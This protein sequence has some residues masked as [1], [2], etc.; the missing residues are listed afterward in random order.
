MEIIKRLW[1]DEAGFIISVE[2][3]LIATI[4]VIGLLV[5]LVTIR[6]SITGELSDVGGAI[7]DLNQSYVIYGIIGPSAA[8]SGSGFADNADTN[9]SPGDPPG[10]M[11]N[12]IVVAPTVGNESGVAPT[13]NG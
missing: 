5:G 12:C 1:N 10:Q 7:G 8:V 13:P 11:D 9:D 6:D 2:L 3:I 4:L